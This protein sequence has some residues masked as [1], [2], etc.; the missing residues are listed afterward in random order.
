VTAAH[1]TDDIDFA[2]AGLSRAA[3]ASACCLERRRRTNW[4]SFD[5]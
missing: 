2:V 4:E 3:A 5:T 1:T